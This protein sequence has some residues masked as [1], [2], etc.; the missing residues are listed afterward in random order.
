MCWG[1]DLGAIPGKSGLG[2][3]P[4][5]VSLSQ[6]PPGMRQQVLLFFGRVLGQL[7][8]PLLHYLNV[9]RPV[10]VRS[11]PSPP[12]P[13]GVTP[14]GNGVGEPPASPNPCPCLPRSCSSSAGTAWAPARRRRRCSSPPSSAPKSSRIPA[15]C[16]ISWRWDSAGS[17][18]GFGLL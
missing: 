14:P 4:V 12:H 6:Y 13:W 2:L 15:C 7:Q 8:H 10:Q 16:P 17:P 5:P 11:Q 18:V 3:T 1:I 9:H